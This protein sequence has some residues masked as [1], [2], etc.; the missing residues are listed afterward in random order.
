MSGT[1]LAV[2]SP[3]SPYIATL[4][5]KNKKNI[6]IYKTKTWEETKTFSDHKSHIYSLGF[7]PDQKYMASAG[8]DKGIKI[9]DI[10][11]KLSDNWKKLKELPGPK[12]PVRSLSF[13]PKSKYLVSGGGLNNNGEIL[14]W[15]IINWTKIK[16]L[17]TSKMV[18]SLSFSPNGN[19]LASNGEDKIKIWNTKTWKVHKVLSSPTPYNNL[20][21]S[22]IC[23]LLEAPTTTEFIS[24]KFEIYS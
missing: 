7:S 16:T 24:P 3:N 4:D 22:T 18:T 2:F 8:Q 12:N 10:S 1:E 17:N 11:D 5:P 15:S 21:F 20:K 14:I 13:S 19:Y 23:S 6:K 9:W